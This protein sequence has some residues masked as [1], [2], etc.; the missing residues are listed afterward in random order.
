M[1]TMQSELKIDFSNIVEKRM[2]LD[3]LINELKKQ[4]KGKEVIK[5]PSPTL[6]EIEEAERTQMQAHDREQLPL[7]SREI[8]FIPPVK[9]KP[10]YPRP[11]IF[12]K[13]PIERQPQ[14][15]PIDPERITISNNK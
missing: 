13:N 6:E 1:E 2:E 12:P 8:G 14:P 11:I 15:K 5:Q 10:Q 4:G 7:Q 9:Y 3:N